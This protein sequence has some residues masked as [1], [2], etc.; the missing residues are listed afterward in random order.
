MDHKQNGSGWTI[1]QI[2][3][4]EKVK[5]LWKNAGKKDDVTSDHNKNQKK[6]K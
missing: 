2:L 3:G 5:K 4:D 6:D 1:M